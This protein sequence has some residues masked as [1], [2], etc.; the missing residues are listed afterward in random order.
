MQPMLQQPI[1]LL[2]KNINAKEAK[3]RLEAFKSKR[4]VTS[5]TKLLAR[6]AMPS[7]C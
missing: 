7:V 4:H 6:V 3:T 2:P 1:T 5:F